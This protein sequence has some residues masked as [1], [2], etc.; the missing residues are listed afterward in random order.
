MNRSLREGCEF[1]S[2]KKELY[3]SL[4]FCSLLFRVDKYVYVIARWGM[5]GKVFLLSDE[6]FWGVKEREGV[7]VNEVF[8]ERFFELLVSELRFF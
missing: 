5:L 1:N 8:E 2:Y 4:F 6:V 7:I 3:K